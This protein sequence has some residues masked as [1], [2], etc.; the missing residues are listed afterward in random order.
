[1][2]HD[3]GGFAYDESPAMDGMLRRGDPW[4]KLCPSKLSAKQLSQSFPKVALIGS[5]TKTIFC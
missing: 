5:V 1:M 4:L 2:F 3:Y